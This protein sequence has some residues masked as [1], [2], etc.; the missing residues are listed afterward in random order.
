MANKRSRRKTP[1]RHVR[2]RAPAK[3][4][5]KMNGLEA[6]YA[7]MLTA[8]QNIGAVIWWAY[9][10]MRFQIGRLAYYTPDFVVQLPDG[11]IQLHE[12]K[13]HWRQAARVRIKCAAE[14]FP[15]D[16]IAVRKGKDG[17]WEFEE[18]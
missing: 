2:A 14:R 10:S 1:P 13:G 16:F 15:F 17:A 7:A 9:E 6:E 4:R 8:R 3:T 12:V 5:G 11:T 18:F